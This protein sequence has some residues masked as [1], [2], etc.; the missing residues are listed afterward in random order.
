MSTTTT[1][2]KHTP[3]PWHANMT[4]GLDENDQP[5]YL[6]GNNDDIFAFAIVNGETW[7]ECAANARLIAAAPKL[8]AELKQ[9]VSRWSKY[10]KK[11]TGNELE[12]Y[13]D[14]AREAI[15]QATAN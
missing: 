13:L 7:D 1:A 15:A 4:E 11:P 10:P 9:F 12:V 5:E 2:E 6:I 8:L 3:G 14:A